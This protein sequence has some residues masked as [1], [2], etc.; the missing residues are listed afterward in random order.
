MSET[1]V[2][3]TIGDGKAAKVGIQKTDCDP[4]F[5]KLDGDLATVINTLTSLVNQ[6][7]AKWQ[8][9]SRY[10]K[11]DLPAPAQPTPTTRFAQQTTTAKPSN[12][13]PPMF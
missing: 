5:F 1:K 10:P 4:V 3:I 12:P 2:V 7:A 8:N 6:A 13:Q 11:A 9:N